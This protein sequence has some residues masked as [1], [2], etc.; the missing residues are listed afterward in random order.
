MS[1]E[2][3]IIQL[4]NRA[5]VAV[6]RASTARQQ[7]EARELVSICDTIIDYYN[8][9]ESLQ[10]QVRNLQGLV[11]TLFEYIGV[12]P[13][14]IPELTGVDSRFMR[15]Q[16]ERRL[17]EWWEQ[18]HWLFHFL[19]NDWKIRQNIIQEIRNYKTLIIPLA[20][21]LSD[22]EIR[23]WEESGMHAQTDMQFPMTNVLDKLETQLVEMETTLLED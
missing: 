14:D 10:A 2:T 1:A 12:I 19:L 22:K 3:A 23:Q 20:Q 13:E 7:A 15:K 4:K 5:E 21:Q 8:Q 6:S 16:L 11:G 18:P 9:T 17:P